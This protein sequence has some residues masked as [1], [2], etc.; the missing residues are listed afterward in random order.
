MM[1]AVGLPDLSDPLQRRLVPDMAAKGVTR[2]RRVNEYAPLSQHFDRLSDEAFLG[3]N[4]VQLQ[5]D[6]H[7]GRL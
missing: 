7:R 5:I 1:I 3:G 4:R 6:A 2:I